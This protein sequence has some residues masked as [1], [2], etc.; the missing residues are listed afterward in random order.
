MLYT[1]SQTRQYSQS[2]RTLPQI[3]EKKMTNILKVSGMDCA[4]CAAAI[5]RF[6]ERKG[7]EE[8]YVDFASGEVRYLVDDDKL[9]LEAVKSGIS[10]LG[11]TVIG[12]DSPK[13]YWTLERKL[14]FCAVFTVPLLFGHMMMA[15]GYHIKILADHYVQLLLCLPVYFLGFRFFGRSA[16]QS[17]RNGL[18][19]MDVLIWMGSTAT[20]AYS[21]AG[22]W[23]KEHDYIFFETCA[24]IITLVLLGNWLERRAVAQ[25]TTAIDELSAIQVTDVVQ[26]MPSG[27]T[28]SMPINAII[29]GD[30]LQVN[31]GDSIPTDGIITSGICSIN[32]SMLTGES[33][34]VVRQIGEAVI[35]G[36]V[37]QSGNIQIR[38][39]A[40]G[41][42]SLLQKMI[43][44][45]KAA[46][47]DKPPVQRLADQI[48]TVFVPIVVTIAAL[49]FIFGYVWFGLSSGEAMLR[50]IA[51]LVVSCPCAMG[52]ATPTAVMVGV[53]R[54]ARNGI[55]V[56][57]A[58]TLEAFSKVKQ[59]VFDKTGTLTK[60]DFEVEHI[61]FYGIEADVANAVIAQLEAKS[62]HP[63]AK[64]VTRYM[65]KWPQKQHIV[66]D[67]FEEKGVGMHGTGPNG[68]K[69]I[70]GSSRLVAGLPGIPV[71]DLY[72]LRNG[73]MV[74][75]LELSDVLRTEAVAAVT[76]L[77]KRGL[78]LHI[79]SGDRTDKVSQVANI[80][81]IDEWQAEQLPA[82]KLEHI[83][84]ISTQSPVAMVGDGINDA[85]A[86]SRAQIGISLGQATASAIA[87]ANIVLLRPDLQGIAKAYGIS[88]ATMK[89][90]EQ[91]LFW[92]FGYN[93]I[94]IPIAVMGHLNPMWGALFMAMSDV[95]V[96]GNSL[97]LRVKKIV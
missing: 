22:L 71:Y 93:I 62:S 88:K 75:G 40:I 84:K 15:F 34:P 70:F 90:I 53:G 27:M 59:V 87:S 82:Q 49:T 8:V 74:A 94:A 66:A 21:L 19:N 92:A 29:V 61:S 23:L 38:V 37:L 25:T 2:C 57:G 77:K 65:A 79:L 12:A 80:L 64:S 31:E 28:I 76:D 97:W 85:A 51:V 41:A 72:L 73:G 81:H 1:R 33:L 44:L 69:Y 67:I 50:A 60:G 68:G 52:L 36:S 46:Q 89:T 3:N 78:L 47:R 14:V 9:P 13:V 18:P 86:L 30:V 35:G 48:S 7:L 11:Y 24:T 4:N 83:A 91:N 56:R 39:T 20:F 45:V 6:L 10:K 54:M 17:V 16:W 5:T 95:V 43:Q 32:E 42:D 58:G 55:L 26:V 63:I 96:I